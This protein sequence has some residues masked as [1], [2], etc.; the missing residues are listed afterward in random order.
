MTVA[1]YSRVYS[2]NAWLKEVFFKEKKLF[3]NQKFYA[4]RSYDWSQTKLWYTIFFLRKIHWLHILAKIIQIIALDWYLLTGICYQIPNS[5]KSST[6]CYTCSLT[7]LLCSLQLVRTIRSPRKSSCTW[8]IIYVLAL[9]FL[10][11]WLFATLARQTLLGFTL[12]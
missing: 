7:P 10:L 2:I 8:T 11:F 4:T 6:N 5:L 3:P 9:F 1:S 12:E